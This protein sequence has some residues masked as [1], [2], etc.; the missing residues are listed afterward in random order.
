MKSIL[1]TK[2]WA[3]LRESQ[4]WK[5]H[6]VDEVLVLEKPL[7]LGF[8]F[9][10]SPEVDFYKINFPKFLPKIKEI[11]KKSHSIFLRLDFLNQKNSVFGGKI[12]TILKKNH[13]IKSFEEIQP[14][15]RQIVDITKSEEEILAK[16][17]PKGRYN[18]KVGQKHG[19][20]VEKS[21]NIDEFY[22]IFKETASRDGFQIRPKKYFAKLIQTLKEINSVELL[23]VKYNDIP[24]AAGIFT[25][26]DEMATY[27]YGAS[28]SKYR[29]VMAPYLMHWEA[30]K[31]AKAKGCKFYD[32]LAVAP[33]NS[34]PERSEG[35]I[36]SSQAQNDK[37]HKYAGITQFKE[38]FG[39]IKYQT[40]GSWDIIYSK[41]W[42][43]L[44]K[45]IEKMRRK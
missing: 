19:L 25:F 30:I 29:N 27:L 22:E 12:T 4:G 42:Y 24:V 44:F 16:M 37:K 35:S 8:S 13:L 10:Y 17:K 38:Q 6:W 5:A 36:D 45:F 43:N 41:C 11:S 20:V 3:A 21:Q 26:F 39:G 15:Y 1:Q 7:P 40:V 18:I 34:H 14:E 28:L 9:L 32:L 33:F 23:V 2:E 31:I